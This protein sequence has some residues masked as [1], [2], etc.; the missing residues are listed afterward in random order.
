MLDHP[1][2]RAILEFI[3]SHLRDK[4]LP[5][6]QGH[7]AFEVRVTISALELV[8]REL[9][10]QP[11]SDQAELSRLKVLLGQG[12][13]LYTLNQRLCD[14]IAT[15]DIGVDTP[16]LLEHLKSTAMEKLAVDQ[17]RYSTYQRTLRKN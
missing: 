8:I 14:L 3:A 17:P 1:N 7:T 2:G 11:A 5:H 6:L 16:G 9:S 4:T 10:L 12:G 15:G 13:D